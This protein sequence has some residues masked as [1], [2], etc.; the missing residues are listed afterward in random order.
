MFQAVDS[1]Y[2]ETRK[3]PLRSLPSVPSTMNV[4]TTSYAFNYTLFRPDDFAT[5]RSVLSLTGDIYNSL[6]PL[7][8]TDQQSLM[9][10]APHI[11]TLFS[12]ADKFRGARNVFTHLGEVLT[13]MDRH[14]LVGP[15]R[16][17]DCNMEYPSGVKGGIHLLWE[18]NRLFY[19]YKG[20]AESVSIEKAAFQPI[21]GSARGL[22]AE[23]ISHTSSPGANP[24]PAP[25]TLYP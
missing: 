16:L 13:D 4:V 23:L 9:E 24:Y 21:F 7:V 8:G 12:E 6:E 11:Q 19:T 20:R 14:G 22:Y 18:N 5:L 3:L 15:I 10:L 17:T 25:A 2:A 1:L